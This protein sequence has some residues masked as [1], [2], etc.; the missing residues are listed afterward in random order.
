MLTYNTN[1]KKLI[2]PEYG[3]IIQEMVDHCLTIEDKE[4]RNLCAQTIVKAMGNLFPS[5]KDG[6]ENRR[7]LWDH[8]AIMADFKLDIDYPYEIVKK[9]SLDSKPEKIAYNATISDNRHYGRHLIAMIQ[10][11]AEMEPS[12]EREALVLLLANQMKKVMLA[13]GND[14]VDDNRIFKDLANISHGTFRF[15]PDEVHLNE[16]NIILP[17]NSKKKKK[18]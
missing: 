10:R 11:A 1:L 5:L 4:Q 16:Y 9:D 8:L 12:E 18:K 2:L 13:S 3:R 17:P 6:D 14:G 7:K 15:N